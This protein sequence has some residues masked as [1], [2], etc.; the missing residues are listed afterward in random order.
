MI[1]EVKQYPNQILRKKSR[2]AEKIIA[3]DNQLIEDMFETMYANNGIGLSACQV[4]K[5]KRIA[6]VDVDG[7]RRVF[8]NPKILS[9]RGKEKYEE[10][11][12]SLPGVFLKIKR[13]QEIEA[14]ALNERGEKFT[15]KANGLLARCIQHEIDHLNGILIID[16]VSLFEKMKKKLFR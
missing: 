10:G 12:L 11:C 7:I 14:E 16:R 15:I 4:G 9:K 3:E 2:P 1:L 8:I 6:V 13:A 5:L